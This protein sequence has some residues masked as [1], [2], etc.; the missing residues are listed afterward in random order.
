MSDNPE[1]TSQDPSQSHDRTETKAVDYARWGDP[2]SYSSTWDQRAA[3]AADLIPDGV[4]VFEIGVG[5]GTFRDLIKHR[6]THIGADL[7]PLDQDTTPL[8]LETDPSA[9]FTLAHGCNAL[10]AGP[11]RLP[12][13]FLAS[14]S[15]CEFAGYR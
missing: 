13:L 5:R 11:E 14:S 1:L 7:A 2:S 3:L 8:N 4:T 15:V 12:G 9:D 10:L 6:C